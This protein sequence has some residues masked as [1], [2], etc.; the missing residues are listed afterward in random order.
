MMFDYRI[1]DYKFWVKLNS[2]T[3]FT[4][5][6][7]NT[8][9]VISVYNQYI[10]L[11]GYGGVSTMEFYRDIIPNCLLAPWDCSNTKAHIDNIRFC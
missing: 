10:N 5:E 1:L 8:G 11:S 2:T 9:G 6:D 3:I 4:S 7:E